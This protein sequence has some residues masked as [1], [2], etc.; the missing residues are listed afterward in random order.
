MRASLISSFEAGAKTSAAMASTVS[1]RADWGVGP[2]AAPFFE[3][4]AE[5]PPL[6]AAA[7]VGK[8]VVEAEDRATTPTSSA[9]EAVKSSKR[10]A[11][12]HQVSLSSKSRWKSW[13]LRHVEPTSRPLSKGS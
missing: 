11:R 13:P 3:E 4:E 8:A 9:G 7:R 10:V 6:A 5:F 1:F 12:R 2:A